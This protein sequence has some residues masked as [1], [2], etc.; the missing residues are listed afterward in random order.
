MVAVS[1]DH[2]PH[3]QKKLV[4]D[5]EKQCNQSAEGPGGLGIIRGNNVGESVS[6]Q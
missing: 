4:T 2:L 5:T 1:K 3:I 6:R